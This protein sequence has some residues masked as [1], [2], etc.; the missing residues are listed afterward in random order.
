MAGSIF[1]S[2][3]ATANYQSVIDRAD[4]SEILL[5]NKRMFKELKIIDPSAIRCYRAGIQGSK[6]AA[7]HAYILAVNTEIT[8]KII[9]KAQLGK[10][11]T[12]TEYANYLIDM[13][14]EPLI[15]DNVS[16][17]D[18]FDV[19]MRYCSLLLASDPK[20]AEKINA[21]IRNLEVAQ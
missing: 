9:K 12:A 10:L 16:V 3:S 15:R 14:N 5:E 20:E 6:K 8:K 2:G 21:I 7:I 4:H 17:L 1:L 13:D 19:S 11:T 18:K